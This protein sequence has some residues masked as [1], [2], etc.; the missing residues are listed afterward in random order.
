MRRCILVLALIVAVTA[1][2]S[3]A[4]VAQTRNVTFIVNSATV[5]DT[6]NSTYSM[7]LRGNTAPLTWGN[8]TGGLLTNIGGDYWS[9]T[10]AFPVGS[11]LRFKIFA[12]TGGWEQD[13]AAAAGG[14]GNRS[15][16]VAD[17]DTVLPVQFFNNLPVGTP[18]Y[19]RP[20]TAE[21]DSFINIF[22]R[23]NMEG[24]IQ[25]GISCFNTDTDTVG[26]R[27][28][29]PA[30]G[31]LNWS[32]T[33]YLV[34]EQ[35]ASN[36]GFGYAASRF[37]SGRLRFPR[38]QVTAGQ[39][40]S[41]KFIVGY[42][43][44][45]PSCPN[46]SEQLS[47]PP[48]TGGNRHFQIPSGLQDTTISYA[49]YQDTRASARVNA[50]TVVSTFRAN[51][52]KALST[53]GFQHG[54]TIVVRTGYFGTATQGGRE[55]QMFRQGFT[56]FYAATDTIVTAVGQTLDYQYYVIKNGQETRENYYN[57][58][59]T[60][61]VSAEAERRQYTVPGSSF[62][63]EDTATSVT[64]AR[65]QP[66]FP[67]TR[68]LARN[69][70]VRW[71]VDLRPAIYQVAAGDT[72]NDIQGSFN[73]YP[74]DIDSILSWG[75]W[76]NGPAVGGWGNP[77]GS[78]WGVGL[79]GNLAKK[80]YDDGTNGDVT[81]GDSIFSRMVLASPDSIGIGSKG[82]VGQTFKFGV[83]AGD[84]EGGRGGFG[85]N[86]VANID[87]S[88]P[89][90]TLRDAFGSINPAFYHAWDYD[91]GCPVVTG[92]H[93]E[94]GIP[95]VFELNQNYP[96]PFNPSTKIEYTIPKQ[97]LVSLKIYNVVGQEVATLVNEVQTASRYSV[98]FNAKNVAS[99][100]YIFRLVAGDF[101]SAKKMVILK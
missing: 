37:W 19:F 15:Y 80:L 94:P 4:A 64:Q 14:N 58:Y 69:V 82:V 41:Y 67:N 17:V 97:S 13:V 100:V 1:V 32:P 95:A 88:N 5:P 34:K 93:P 86:H 45:T 79:Q 6:V 28:G 39:D 25:S 20:W 9:V 29:G 56:N 46:R 68:T 101:V 47:D 73:I 26:V 85:N 31:D 75:V 48:H 72:L 96:N 53:G 60:G 30:G 7:Q 10:L 38:S 84:N 12:G 71:E 22:M 87:D 40:I 78:D 90:Y 27:G 92:V 50:D 33:F 62:T 23:V 74:T 51:M 70:D 76:M 54:D 35:G 2:L 55:K 11:D 59:Y 91:C 49:F 81:A 83:H 3:P 89:T 36:G 65:R 61:E 42:D 16:T 24:A 63:L 98:T 99:G 77:G 57:F 52:Q 43:W 66:V 8:D 21:A 44:G 18:Q